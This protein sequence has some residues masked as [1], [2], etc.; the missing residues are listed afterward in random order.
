MENVTGE[1][2]KILREKMGWTKSAVAK[3][4]GI[5]TVSTY[6]NWEYGLRQPDYET[7]AKIADL[8]EVDA[9]YLIGRT[10]KPKHPKE[11]PIH[12]SFSHGADP[13]TDEEEEYLERQLEE[14]RRLR[15]KFGQ[16]DKKD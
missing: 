14:F 10:D 6:A 9:D 5:K 7:L 1:R 8:F 15:K 11:K 16:E 4:L 2:L 12:I 3:K 13:L